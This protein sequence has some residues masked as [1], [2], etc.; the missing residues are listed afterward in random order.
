MTR[1][2]DRVPRIACGS[3]AIDDLGALAA[4]RVGGHGAVLLV[5]DPGLEPFGLVDAAR[6]SIERAGL[7]V[8]PFMDVRSDP[9]ASQVDAG[10]ELAW[11]SGTSAVVALGGGSALDAGKAIAALA[12]GDLP[13]V[14][15]ALCARPLPRSPLLKICVP[16][17]AGTGS[18]TTRTAIVTDAAGNKV[19]L[20]G[21][22]LKADEVLLD[23]ELTVDLPPHLTAATGIDALVHAIEA[24]TN[25][26]AA[27]ITDLFCHE[28]IRLTARW[29]P[30]AVEHPR[31]LAAR[32]A[33]QRAACL[34]GIAIDNAG[35]AMAHNLGH[36][37]ASLRP[38]HHGRAVGL[39][40]LATLP[41]S[42]AH[43][44]E[45]RWAAVA[46]AMGAPGGA[47]GAA[48][49]FERLLRA[50]GVAVALGPDGF[51]DVAPERLA[52][53]MARPENAS[54]RRSNAREVGDD[55]LLAFARRVLAQE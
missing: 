28:A 36:A 6:S 53:Q 40:M 37:L 2:L 8:V 32:E 16:T 52:A 51:G 25:R 22:E 10:V 43:D 15:Y 17:T 9:L 31:D 46:D 3:G 24:A 27:P 26:N 34:A 13:A 1:L 48:P 50:V 41:W 30:R 7:A 20:W 38:I 45:G 23:P 44:P 47:A 19:W 21:D 35:T 39:A 54:M 42:T 14:A 11:R 55:D 5:A 29:L 49:A 12:R 33:M 4:A 18:E